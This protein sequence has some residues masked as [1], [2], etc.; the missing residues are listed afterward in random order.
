MKTLKEKFNWRKSVTLLENELKKAI[1][2][3]K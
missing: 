2:R 1:R 3:K